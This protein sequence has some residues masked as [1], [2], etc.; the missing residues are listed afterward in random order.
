MMA[1]RSSF[2]SQSP[3]WMAASFHG[4]L[5]HTTEPTRST[6]GNPTHINN[7]RPSTDESDDANETEQDSEHISNDE[8]TNEFHEHHPDGRSLRCVSLRSQQPL[9]LRA[10]NYVPCRAGHE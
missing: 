3:A 5:S 6:T 8:A 4:T 10:E 9:S 7:P 1:M 2:T